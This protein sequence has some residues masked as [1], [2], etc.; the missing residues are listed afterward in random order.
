MAGNGVSGASPIA[1]KAMGV[2]RSRQTGLQHVTPAPA[3][4]WGCRLAIACA[5]QI[6]DDH[7]AA[8]SNFLLETTALKIAPDRSPNATPLV[9][10]RASRALGDRPGTKFCKT[11]KAPLAVARP[12]N[13]NIRCPER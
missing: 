4:P 7:V 1:A 11:S 12:I 5:H 3:T 2:D 6:N 9:L 8:R 13:A 10:A